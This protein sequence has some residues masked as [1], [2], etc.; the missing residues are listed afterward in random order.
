MKRILI[1]LLMTFPNTGCSF[2]T[3]E[4]IERCGIFLKAT[5]ETS[6]CRC[7]MYK[8]DVLGGKRVS[9]SVDMPL[10]YCDRGVVYNTEKN[11]AWVKIRNWIDEVILWLEDQ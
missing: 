4:P 1:L 7:A 8:L 10:N 3:I 6:K 2:P 9:E 5:I 11:G